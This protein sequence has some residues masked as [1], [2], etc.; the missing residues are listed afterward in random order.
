MV[1]WQAYGMDSKDLMIF[2]VFERD[3]T[4]S[5][6][7]IAKE[8]GI[9]SESV[10]TRIH[11][12]KH[13]G[14][15]RPDRTIQDPLLGKRLQTEIEV[16]YDPE[17]L[18]LLR[19]HVFFIDVP[20]RESLNRLK[21]FCDD[22]PYTHYRTLAYAQNATLYAQFDIPSEISKE[23]KKLYSS[24]QEQGLCK[25]IET[26]DS[27]VTSYHSADF[28]RWDDSKNMWKVH[29]D[30]KSSTG[31][32]MS[33]LESMWN[34][35]REKQTT[36]ETPS[37]IVSPLKL[38]GLD[39]HLLRELTI[40]ALPNIKT[41]G[42]YYKRD[43]TTISRRV[44]RIRENLLSRTIL[45]YN[46]ALFDLTYPQFILG[47]FNKSDEMDLEMIHGFIRSGEIPFECRLVSDKSKFLLYVISP[48]SFGPEFSEFFWEH[49]SN[50]SLFQLQLNASFTYYFYPENYTIDG[51]KTENDYVT[52]QLLT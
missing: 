27:V 38:D 52:S 7:V 5:N 50:I 6:M 1:T 29:Y 17:K 28:K 39:M 41:L 42:A 34:R 44:K 48:P 3:P 36:L 45:Y 8:V 4:M 23:M 16:A 9:S 37:E 21:Q 2:L 11:A 15:L 31:K 32:R 33:D 12:M 35:Y 49:S 51:W 14:F 18:G 24:F 40:N 10:R 43:P 30:F 46:R 47:K 20:N 22:H 13:K 25:H 26:V 19:Q